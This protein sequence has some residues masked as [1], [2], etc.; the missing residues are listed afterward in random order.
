M[1][2]ELSRKTT[3][4]EMVV[5]WGSIGCGAGELT[6]KCDRALTAQSRQNLTQCNHREEKGWK[7]EGRRQSKY[8][9]E[10]WLLSSVTS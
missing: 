10:P 6:G 5:V 7:W 8:G 9:I 4:G 3:L 2:R 1:R